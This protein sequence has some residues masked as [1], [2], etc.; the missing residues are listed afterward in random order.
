MTTTM[1]SL[2]QPTPN[3]KTC[4]SWQQQSATQEQK[5]DVAVSFKTTASRQPV[6]VGN[7]QQQSAEAGCAITTLVS[8]T[9]NNSRPSRYTTARST[10]NT[11]TICE[12]NNNNN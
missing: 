6:A 8:P 5:L 7:G 3:S 2:P 12:M 1:P 10:S 9:N 4:W 11:T